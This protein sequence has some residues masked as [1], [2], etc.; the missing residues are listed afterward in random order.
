MKSAVQEQSYLENWRWLSRQIRCALSP[1]DPRIIEDYM[2]EGRFLISC[3]AASAWTVARTA[4]R[5]LLDTATDPALPWHWR[6]LCLDQA[7]RP[8]RDMR[9]AAR[10]AEHLQLWHQHGRQL[11]VCTLEPSIS[12]SDLLQGHPDE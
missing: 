12:F 9:L 5:L 6:C 11:A 10:N 8:L 1:N 4:F 7:Y 3:G 2:A